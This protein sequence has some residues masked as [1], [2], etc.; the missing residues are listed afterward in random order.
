L[1][2]ED[3]L[4]A[5]GD[6]TE[7]SG[8]RAAVQLLDEEPKAIFAASDAMATGA[9]RCLRDAGLKVPDEVA[10]IGFDGLPASAGTH[11]P[12]TTVKQPITRMGTVAAQTLIEQIEEREI[13]PRH[14]VLP[15][16]LIVRQ[17][18]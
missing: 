4:V 8:Y 13:H 6:F 16:E 10:V 18:T 1:A 3:N 15:V 9:L 11:P 14:I 5:E 7:E 2:F 17:S 12:L